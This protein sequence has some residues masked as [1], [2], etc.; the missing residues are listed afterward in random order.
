LWD[1]VVHSYGCGHD[2]EFFFLNRL[3]KSA[4]Q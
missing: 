1:G 3:N 2:D 4:I